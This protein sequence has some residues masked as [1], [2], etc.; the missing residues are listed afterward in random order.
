MTQ[1]TVLSDERMPIG[2]VK[3]KDNQSGI[4]SV[5]TIPYPNQVIDLETPIIIIDNQT[6]IFVQTLAEY[7]NRQQEWS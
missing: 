6:L 2:Q 7:R 3:V 5:Y 4:T 1:Y